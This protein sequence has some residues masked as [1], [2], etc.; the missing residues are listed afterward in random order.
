MAFG[1]AQRLVNGT[2]KFTG[3]RSAQVKVIDRN[4]VVKLRAL[5]LSANGVEN[6]P[7]YLNY[8]KKSSICGMDLTKGKASHVLWGIEYDTVGF[9][10]TRFEQAPDRLPCEPIKVDA[11]GDRSAGKD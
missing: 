3:C 4:W 9:R 11:Y 6:V 7:P 2:V 8:C 10:H 5:L 1:T